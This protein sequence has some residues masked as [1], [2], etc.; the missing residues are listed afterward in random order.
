MNIGHIQGGTHA[1]W[2]TQRPARVARDCPGGC[3]VIKSH[4][5]KCQNCGLVVG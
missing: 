4:Y 2:R 5:A 1:G 3:G